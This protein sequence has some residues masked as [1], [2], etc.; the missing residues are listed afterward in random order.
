VSWRL[1]ATEVDVKP[2]VRVTILARATD[3]NGEVQPMDAEVNGGRLWQQLDPQGDGQCH[4]VG[5]RP[6]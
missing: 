6:C 1:W 2:P 5:S 4:A 3:Q